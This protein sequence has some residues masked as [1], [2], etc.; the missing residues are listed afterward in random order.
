MFSRCISRE[1][2]RRTRTADNQTKLENVSV[3]NKCEP[4]GSS[5]HFTSC[6]RARQQGRRPQRDRLV[7][8]SQPCSVARAVLFLRYEHHAR[9]SLF[10]SSRDSRSSASSE[11]QRLVVQSSHGA[12]RF[13]GSCGLP[14]EKRRDRGAAHGNRLLASR[15]KK[16]KM[17]GGRKGR[18]VEP[19]ERH[20]WQWP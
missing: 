20:R 8:H 6:L 14:R 11:S 9:H 18:K 1:K 10:V 13:C 19:C 15:T 2:K 3:E 17:A 7:R 4:L 5:K 16:T 12:A